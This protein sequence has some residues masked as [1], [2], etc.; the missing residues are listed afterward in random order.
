M[1]LFPARGTYAGEGK[2]LLKISYESNAEKY[3]D[4]DLKELLMVL[5]EHFPTYLI[6]MLQTGAKST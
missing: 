1:G 2:E 6:D 3:E 5:L 4:K